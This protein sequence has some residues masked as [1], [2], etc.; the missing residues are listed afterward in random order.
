MSVNNK[1][2]SL[3]L[4]EKSAL[5]QNGLLGNFLKSCSL[6]F[7]YYVDRIRANKGLKLTP[8]VFREKSCLAQIGTFSNWVIS[9]CWKRLK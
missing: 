3:I 9:F 7:S 4:R 2:R 6:I 8:T 5:A 1:D